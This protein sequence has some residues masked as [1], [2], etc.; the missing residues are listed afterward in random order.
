M[1]NKNTP[2]PA[3][4]KQSQPNLKNSGSKAKKEAPTAWIDR[5]NSEDYEQLRD[6]FLVFDV[7]GSGTIDP[8]EIIKVLE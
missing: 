7:D 5:V 3:T 2:V 1:K 8:Q 4:T 6:V